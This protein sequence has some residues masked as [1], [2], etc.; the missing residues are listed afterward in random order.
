MT[1]QADPTPQAMPDDSGSDEISLAE[2]AAVLLDA[3]WL[4]GAIAGAIFLV[5]LSYALFAAPVYTPSALL[6]V[7]QKA[8]GLS[9]LETLSSMLEGTAL[10]V[11]AEIQLAQSSSVLRAAVEAQH[12]DVLVRPRRF[13]LLGGLLARRYRGRGS[14]PGPT[15]ARPASRGATI[16]SPSAGSTFPAAGTT[17]TSGSPSPARMPTDCRIPTATPCSRAGPVRWHGATAPRPTT[18]W[19]SSSAA[20]TRAPASPSRCAGWI[21]RRR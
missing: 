9:G 4:V 12:A 19:P 17:R 20:S 14:G 18:R 10:P 8:G 11:A 1:A 3:K 5:V 13:P 16:T 21:C 15:R 7:N 2:L 6:Q